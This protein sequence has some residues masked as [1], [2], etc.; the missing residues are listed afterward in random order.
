MTHTQTHTWRLSIDTWLLTH[1]QSDTLGDLQ[2]HTHTLGD[3]HTHTL[4]DLHTQTQT[5]GDLYT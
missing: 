5:L 1:T 3:L 2:L 4:G